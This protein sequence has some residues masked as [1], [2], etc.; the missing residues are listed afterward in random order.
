MMHRPVSLDMA[1]LPVLPNDLRIR[2]NRLLRLILGSK[3]DMGDGDL[4]TLA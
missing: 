4:I 2:L 3:N 1:A